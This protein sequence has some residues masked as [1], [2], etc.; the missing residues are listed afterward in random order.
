[1]VSLMLDAD[2]APPAGAVVAALAG[3]V[4]VLGMVVL[5]GLADP[6]RILRTA[7]P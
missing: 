4:A 6:A 7:R 5:R 2:V 3:M 1:V